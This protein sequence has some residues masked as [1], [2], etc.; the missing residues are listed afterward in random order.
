MASPSDDLEGLMIN[1]RVGRRKDP[2][3]RQVEMLGRWLVREVG[4][5]DEAERKAAAHAAVAALVDGVVERLSRTP[6][7]RDP[8]YHD[9]MALALTADH[10][11]EYCYCPPLPPLPPLQPLD[12][13]SSKKATHPSRPRTKPKGLFGKKKGAL[14]EKALNQGYVWE[15]CV[16]PV[17]GNEWD[18]WVPPPPIPTP[19]PAPQPLLEA[20]G[21]LLAASGPDQKGPPLGQEPASSAEPSRGGV[22][23]VPSK[24]RVSEPATPS[25]LRGSRPGTP[26]SKPGTPKSRPVTPKSVRW[27]EVTA[28]GLQT[29]GGEEASPGNEIMA[30]F[31]NSAML[32]PLPAQ[33]QSAGNGDAASPLKHSKGQPKGSKGANVAQGG[34][35]VSGPSPRPDLKRG[36]LAIGGFSPALKR[37]PSTGSGGSK[38]PS[39]APA[40]KPA[41]L[42]PRRV[43]GWACVEADVVMLQAGVRAHVTRCKVGLV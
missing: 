24:D 34:S 29:I 19:Q 43:P 22:G 37:R 9:A 32:T 3:R 33:G 26:K 6:V 21:A 41:R 28:R 15:L 39:G 40:K 30:R 8:L 36:L 23:R 35:H 13:K 1:L 20:T 16:V 17:L 4:L 31:Q 42:R 5:R 2:I 18:D 25:A 7:A 11:L 14:A 27:G 12:P 38:D 10:G